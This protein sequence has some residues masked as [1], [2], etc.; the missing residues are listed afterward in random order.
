MIYS[1][2]AHGFSSRF[3][4]KKVNIDIS[5]LNK[6]H[7]GQAIR[8]QF[9]RVIDE[10]PGLKDKLHVIVCDGASSNATVSLNRARHHCSQY[11]LFIHMIVAGLPFALQQHLVRGACVTFVR[12][13]RNCN[14]THTRTRHS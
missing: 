9:E 6:H 13:G 2:T 5:P 8:E 3:E 4:R 11:T 10:W 7:T 1:V 14:A 12:Q